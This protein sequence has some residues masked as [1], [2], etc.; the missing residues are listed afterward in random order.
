MVCVSVKFRGV[1]DRRGLVGSEDETEE[2]PDPPSV[3]DPLFKS[4][5][6]PVSSFDPYRQKHV[7]SIPTLLVELH[8][9]TPV[10]TTSSI[11]PSTP[12]V[13]GDKYLKR[14]GPYHVW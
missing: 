12:I 7:L 10:S 6:S 8:P 14:R 4:R 3:E 1:G 2:G 13:I 11:T 5:F 9:S